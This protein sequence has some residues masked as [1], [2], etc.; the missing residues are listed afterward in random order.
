MRNWE[1]RCAPL[2]AARLRAKRRG[3][4]GAKWHADEAY[5]RVAGHWCSPYRVI[6]R[7]GN[8]VDALLSERRDMAAA[9]RFFRQALDIVGRPPE[10]VTTDG[11]DTYPQAIRGTLGNGV[12]HRVNCR[13]QDGTVK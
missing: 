9:Q 11:H 6:D 3:Q 1:A 7:E 12:T 13:C 5:L 8:L 2:L 10:Q 4:G